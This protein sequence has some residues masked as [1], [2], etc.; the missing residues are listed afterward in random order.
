MLALGYIAEGMVR[1]A[2]DAGT[3]RWLA[4]LE[5][6]FAVSFFIAAVCYAHATRQ[7]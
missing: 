3:S 6:L 7:T 4:G 5:I 2:S 1:I